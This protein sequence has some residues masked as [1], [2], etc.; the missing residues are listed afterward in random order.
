MKVF[1]AYGYNDRDKWIP[2]M[3]FPIL[4]AFGIEVVTGE[5]I[6]G[7]IISEEVRERIRSSDALLGFLTRRD[8]LG[9]GTYSTHQWVRDEIAQALGANRKF[10]EVWETGL[11]I[12]PGATQDRQHLKYD[13][14]QRDKFLVDLVKAI[15]G[16]GILRVRLLPSDF[17]DAINSLIMNGTNIVC[18]YRF[19]NGS[20]QSK[21]YTGS[22]F[23]LA[24]GV[25]V[26]DV[27]TSGLPNRRDNVFIQVSAQAHGNIWSS[28][29]EQ[30]DL[31][32]VTMQFT[33]Q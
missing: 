25:V 20:Q 5:D 4:M 29:Y 23:S 30:L 17:C 18:Q 15:S 8:D 6:A 28:R 1:V 12:P 26:I 11:N 7:D 21:W 31:L 27:D 22:L 32:S 10:I 13:A 3:V 9:N 24:S 2:E 14:T 19:L 16:W 33:K